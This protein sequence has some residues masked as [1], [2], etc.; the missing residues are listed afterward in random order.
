VFAIFGNTPKRLLKIA[1][2][3]RRS[4]ALTTGVVIVS[5]VRFLRVGEE[6]AAARG[7]LGD[8]AGV[9]DIVVIVGFNNRRPGGFPM[10]AVA[11]SSDWSR[12]GRRRKS[13]PGAAIPASRAG[14]FTSTGCRYG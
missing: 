2:A 9:D 10:C 1:H 5:V 3:N 12:R 8:R 4:Q 11:I 13:T 14:S 7:S 6:D